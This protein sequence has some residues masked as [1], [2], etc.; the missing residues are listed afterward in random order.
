M[1]MAETLGVLSIMPLLSVLAHPEAIQENFFLKTVYD[2][3]G[4][5]DPRSFIFTLGIGS[6]LLV[7]G[8]SAFKTITLYVLNRSVNSQG[9][10]RLLRLAGYRSTV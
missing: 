6:I 2:Q 4:F 3:S 8:S 9:T 5:N 1:A 7:V 10:E